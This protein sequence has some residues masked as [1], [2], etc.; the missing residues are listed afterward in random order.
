MS[1]IKRPRTDLTRKVPPVF[2]STTRLT[3]VN[4][5]Q[6]T[7]ASPRRG[8]NGECKRKFGDTIHDPRSSTT[9]D[10]VVTPSPGPAVQ[11]VPAS[12]VEDTSDNRAALVG[13]SISPKRGRRYFSKTTHPVSMGGPLSTVLPQVEDRDTAAVVFDPMPSSAIA[14]NANAGSLIRK[15]KVRG[16]DHLDDTRHHCKRKGVARDIPLLAAVQRLREARNHPLL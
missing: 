8:A 6:E 14:G 1:S 3:I 10:S 4:T 9:T 15:R 13:N 11:S 5:P 16:P 12:A 2:V 7:P